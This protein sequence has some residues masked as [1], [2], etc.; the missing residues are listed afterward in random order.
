MDYRSWSE[1]AVAALLFAASLL[2]A[3]RAAGQ[4]PPATGATEAFPPASNAEER[5]DALLA[6]G[7]EERAAGDEQRAL[8]SFQAAYDLVRSSRARGQMGLAA[9]SVRSFVL[10][11]QWLLEALADDKGPWVAKNRAL[12][13][14]ALSLVQNNLAWLDVRAEPARATLIANGRR[15]VL[16]LAQPLRVVAGVTHIELTAAGYEPYSTEQTVPA[17]QT[18]ALHVAL[19]PLATTARAPRPPHPPL[20]PLTPARRVVPAAS[21]GNLRLRVLGYS[22]GAL[23]TAGVITAGVVAIRVLDVKERRDSICPA[24]RCPTERG[25]TLDQEARRLAGFATV[26]FTVSV[27]ALGAS[28]FTLVLEHSRSQPRE[29]TVAWHLGLGA[30]GRLSFAARY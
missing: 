1:P 20:A 17:R 5:A 4:V 3:S 22:L 7:V 14:D 16:P 10:A 24:S 18:T 11:E 8:E 13:E 9:K 19:T 6:Q 29:P 12:L 30:D 21:A 28:A 26:A 27:V 25:V 2:G 23:G 15:E